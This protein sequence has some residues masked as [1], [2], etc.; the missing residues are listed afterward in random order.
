M[1][2][3]SRFLRYSILAA[4]RRECPTLA[5]FRPHDFHGSIGLSIRLDLPRNIRNPPSQ[6]S[7]SCEFHLAMS[8]VYACR[9]GNLCRNDAT[10]RELPSLVELWDWPGKRSSRCASWPSS[11]IFSTPLCCRHISKGADSD[12][13]AL[14][15]DLLVFAMYN[16]KDR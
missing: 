11:A 16:L 6:F 1:A 8:P 7:R 4:V 12:L 3:G 10:K 13:S 15:E 9:K 5:L 2:S 14:P